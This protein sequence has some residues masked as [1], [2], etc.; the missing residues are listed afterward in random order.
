[1]VAARPSDKSYLTRSGLRIH[2][3]DWGNAAA[4]PLVLIHGLRSHAH[5]WDLVVPELSSDYHILSLDVRGRGDS[6]WDP[7]CN[8]NTPTYV[9]DV[10]DLV[11][12]LGLQRMV[13]MGHSMGGA[14]TILYASTHPDQVTGAVI[15]DS[16]PQGETPTP[17]SQRITR[18]V[19]TTPVTFPSW[20]QAKAFLRQQ[21]P[22]ASEESMRIRLQNTL[23]E[24]PD[25]TVTWRYDHRGL[26][27]A[28]RNPGPR[29]DMWPYVRG[30]RCPT[31]IVRGGRS[32]VF[33]A[34]TA[35]QMVQAMPHATWVEIPNAGHPVWDD[36]LTDFNR[37]VA[38]FLR[39]LVRQGIA[40]A[41]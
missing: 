34:E 32:D 6:A 38:R 25:G 9:S 12:A 29:V 37:E 39:G 7:L 15:V 1:M 28:R 22:T 8:Y 5:A 31:L 27:E 19:E 40:R 30:I 16:G 23:K 17:G 26:L 14:I 10:E 3:L 18:E 20:D 41:S 35:Q 21:R 13:L 2:Y 4:T 11:A 33:M 36:N 24:L